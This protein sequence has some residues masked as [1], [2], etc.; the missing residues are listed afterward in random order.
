MTAYTPVLERTRGKTVESLHYGAAT[1]V[2]SSGKLL[3]WIGDPQLTTFLRSAAKPFQALPFIEHGGA[4]AFG[5]LPHEIAQ[6]CASHGGTDLHAQTVC[7]IQAKVGVDESYLQCGSHPPLDKATTERLIAEG[8]TPT[9]IRH[10]CS[11]KHS[12]MLA[13]AQ[14]RGLPLENY[15]AV[16]H[17]IQKDILQTFAEMCVIEPAEIKLGTDGCSAPNFA[18]P[19]YNAALGFARLCDPRDLPAERSQACK[20]ITSAMMTHPEYVSGV[21]RFDTRLMQ[22]GCGRFVVKGGAEGYQALGIL[23]DLTEAS[24]KGV[25]IALKI[26][27]GD[28]T[29]KVRAAVMI[30]I[31]HQLGY[32]DAAQ[33]MA[34]AEFAPVQSIYNWR[35]LRIGESR[36][37]FEL[38]KENG[39][40]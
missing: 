17:P 5:L 33:L 2:D 20:T 31:L 14:M 6:I 25:G 39:R 10:N 34:L 22:V 7:G 23:P 35:K 27:D 3:A 15:L 30:E 38:E 36:T 19:L 24:P 32:L 28:A 4:R 40:N 1:V 18:I 21:G 9:P 12:G 8:K 26:S 29:E 13:H 37:I 16:E 11:G